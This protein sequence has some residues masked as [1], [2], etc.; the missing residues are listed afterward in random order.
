VQEECIVPNGEV[1]VFSFVG[2]CRPYIPCNLQDDFHHR[3]HIGPFFLVT[4]VW[5]VVRFAFDASWF[6]MRIIFCVSIFLAV[7]TLSNI[8][9]RW[10]KFNFAL[11][12]IFYIKYVLIIRGISSV[13]CNIPD[14]CDVYPSFSILVLISSGLME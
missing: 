13:L 1:G 14:I 7:C 3:E 2:L 8:V 4:L 11:L 9:F 10:F 6:E 12:Y 5:Q